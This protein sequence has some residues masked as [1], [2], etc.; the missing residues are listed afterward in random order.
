MLALLHFEWKEKQKFPQWLENA[1]NNCWQQFH[2]TAK[3]TS[4]MHLPNAIYAN[5]DAKFENFFACSEQ[6]SSLHSQHF[7]SGKNF[8]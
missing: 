3:M 5:S 2:Y 7:C 4:N 1:P 6:Q 8:H